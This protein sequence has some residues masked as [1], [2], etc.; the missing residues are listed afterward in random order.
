MSRA[1]AI[2]E[3]D[4][5]NRKFDEE[6]RQLEQEFQQRREE[7]RQ[8]RC[9]EMESFVRQMVEGALREHQIIGSFPMPGLPMPQGGTQPIFSPS[10]GSVIGLASGAPPDASIDTT[11]R[12]PPSVAPA[13]TQPRGIHTGSL[14]AERMRNSICQARQFSSNRDGSTSTPIT[15]ATG[16]TT[17]TLQRPPSSATLS[18]PPYTNSPNS[19]F[20][21]RKHNKSHL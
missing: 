15:Q 8:R 13:R 17:R 2:F 12:K 4:G 9:Q 11:T 21:W 6:E 20:I 14:T 10:N 16:D 3:R 18:P 5:L 19:T 1:H 7:L